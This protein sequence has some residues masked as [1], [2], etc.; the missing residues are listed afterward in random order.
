M[1]NI[2]EIKQQKDIV[3]CE[4]EFVFIDSNG[5]MVTWSQSDEIYITGNELEVAEEKE[6]EYTPVRCTEL[7][8]ELK[9]VLIENIKKYK[10]P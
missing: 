5:N 10:Q 9:I 2:V 7:S 8:E 4:H 3:L 1:S 6:R